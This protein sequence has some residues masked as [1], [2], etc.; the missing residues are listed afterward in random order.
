MESLNL[1]TRDGITFQR[2][3]EAVVAVIKKEQED[4]AC[5]LVIKEKC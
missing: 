3:Q 5:L 4:A 2:G 1:L